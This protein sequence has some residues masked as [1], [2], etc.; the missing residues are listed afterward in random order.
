MKKE[1]QKPECDIVE[2]LTEIIADDI[3]IDGD[4]TGDLIPGSSIVDEWD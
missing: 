2:F 3:D 4:G 1:Y